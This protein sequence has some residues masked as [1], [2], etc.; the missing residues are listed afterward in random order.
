MAQAVT[1][2]IPLQALTPPRM[3]EELSGRI[4]KLAPPPRMLEE[5]S[6]QIGK[7]LM[8][9]G[10]RFWR[11][12]VSPAEF[13]A[14]VREQWADPAVDERAALRRCRRPTATERRVSS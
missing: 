2:T 6:G 8:P 5:L 3:L 14:A 4:D 10:S 7:W 13:K 9:G 11:I 1:D 12:L